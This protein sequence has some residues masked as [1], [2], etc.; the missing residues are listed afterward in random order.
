MRKNRNI[1]LII[2]LFA[3]IVL[4]LYLNSR[5]IRSKRLTLEDTHFSVLDT[6]RI[7]KV[8]IQSEDISNSLVRN[9]G[10]WSIND[11]YNVDP[12]M[13]TVLLTLLNRVRPQRPVPRN[14]LSEIKDQLTKSGTKVEIFSSDGLLQ[15]YLAGGNG[16]SVSYLMKEGE[17][18]YI[19][20]LPGYDSYVSGIFE[21]SENDWR[22]RFVFS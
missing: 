15:I 17:D 8:V 10:K 22:D 3:L 21:V 4:S 12:S 19:V 11:K 5:G 9:D 14:M 18:P 2:L 6:T 16:I 20:H 1:V 13:R 7:E